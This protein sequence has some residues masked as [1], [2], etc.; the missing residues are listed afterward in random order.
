MKKNYSQIIWWLTVATFLVPL[1]VIPGSFIFPFIVPKAL[2]FRMLVLCQLGVFLTA[3][4]AHNSDLKI[5]PT[6][7]SWAV[8]AFALS[9]TLSTFLGTDVHHS[10]WDNHE[11]MLGLFTVLHYVIYFFILSTIFRTKD[12]WHSL[13]RLFLAAGSVV[14]LIGLLQKISPNF[15][16]NNGSA[17]V[18]ATLGNAIYLGAYGIFLFF[19]SLY[20]FFLEKK[21]WYLVGSLLAFTGILISGTRGSVLG[22]VAGLGT[23]MTVYFLTLPK[24]QN[25]ARKWLGSFAIGL[26]LVFGVLFAFRHTNTVQSLPAVGSLVNTTIS[27]TASTRLMAWKIAIESWQDKPIFGWGPNNFFYAFNKYYNPEFLRFGWG[28]TWFDNA[29]NIILNTLATQGLV[30]VV[31]YLSL[32]GAAVFLLIRGYRQGRVSQHLTA[33]GSAF[34]AGHLVQNIFVFENITSYLYFFFFLAMVSSLSL[35]A[36]TEPVKA[37]P[38]LS[39]GLLGGMWAVLALLIFATNINVARANSG[40]INTLQT[41]YQGG[42]VI[43]VYNK[44]SQIGSPHQADNRLDLGRAIT[45]I[46]G[47]YSEQNR[48]AEFQPLAELAIQELDKNR[49]EH[50][51]DIRNQVQE[52]QLLQ[53]AYEMYHNTDHLL[54]ANEILLEAKTKSP[55]RQQVDYML[56]G[57]K[58]S[59]GDKKT[60]VDILQASVERTPSIGEGWWRLI[61]TLQV[62]GDTAGAKAKA[63]EARER[64]IVFDAIGESIVGPLAPK[65]TTTQ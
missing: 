24:E 5:R 62:S 65:A 39:S 55:E 9:F 14:M 54:K 17:R 53:I 20:F 4:Y 45:Q 25:K 2:A 22:L 33:V 50:P 21:W 23:M 51:Y 8:L 44:N 12:V 3:Y 36:D 30:G 43:A 64:G 49:L 19:V 27:G 29:H 52:A 40:M 31:T 57:I 58:I 56:S 63:L 28:E 41:I 35:G 7:V 47:Q 61:Y 34:L 13:L 16:L 59:L 1:I 15:L 26:V 38:V 37:R 6:A 11:R 48:Q 10:L 18:S 60:A 42:D 46:A 32:F